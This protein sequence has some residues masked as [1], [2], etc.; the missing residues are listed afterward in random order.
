MIFNCPSCNTSAEYEPETNMVCKMC[1]YQWH[2]FE[3]E[4]ILMKQL[5]L[6]MNIQDVQVVEVT[7]E[8]HS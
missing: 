6:L 5:D 3:T 2:I 7:G 1:N 8:T 4:V